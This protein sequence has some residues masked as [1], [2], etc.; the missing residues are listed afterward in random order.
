M[1]IDGNPGTQQTPST[2]PSSTQPK[3]PPPPSGADSQPTDPQDKTSVSPVATAAAASDQAHVDEQKAAED[4]GESLGDLTPEEKKEVAEI[5]DRVASANADIRKASHIIHK[6]DPELTP[7][8]AQAEAEGQVLGDLAPSLTP[9]QRSEVADRLSDPDTAADAQDDLFALSVANYADKKLADMGTNQVTVQPWGT[10]KDDCVWRT[11]KSSG[12]TDEQIRDQGLVDEV[13]RRNGLED[14]DLV[15]PGQKLDV[16]TPEEMRMRNLFGASVNYL[17]AKYEAKA[18]DAAYQQAVSDAEPGVYQ[19]TYADKY[20]DRYDKMNTLPTN[21]DRHWD[22][23]DKM[24]AQAPPDRS[25]DEIEAIRSQR[26][27]PPVVADPSYDDIESIR[28]RRGPMNTTPATPTYNYGSVRWGDWTAAFG[29][30]QQFLQ[31]S[32]MWKDWTVSLYLGKL[33]DG[34]AQ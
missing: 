22:R 27:P 13:A 10:G 6:T 14:P 11:L 29:Q 5:H 8:E 2:G 20:A 34:M 17:V 33:P 18:A 21:P 25:Y 23:Y 30:G 19:P 9:G 32:L 16:P 15:H 4:F 12:W 3:A 28:A 26:T 1:V 31:G 7:D 24:N